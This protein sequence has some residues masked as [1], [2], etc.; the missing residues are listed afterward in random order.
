MWWPQCLRYGHHLHWEE[1]GRENGSRKE[2]GG[3]EK[4]DGRR[5]GKEGGWRNG[6]ERIEGEEGL[7]VK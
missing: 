1:G 3:R 4:E 6:S 2:E 7:V 5:R